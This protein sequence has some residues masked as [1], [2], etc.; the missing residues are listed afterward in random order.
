VNT[1]ELAITLLAAERRVLE[2]QTKLHR[3]ATNDP[4]KK[5]DDLFN[6]VTDPAFLLVA[7]DRV[8]GNKG[9]KTPGVDGLTAVSVQ[10]GIG[11][12]RF[13]SELR[14]ALKDR[15][16]QPLPVRERMIPKADGKLRRLGIPT[17]ADRVVQASLKLVLEP[18]FEADFHPCSYGFRPNRRAHDAVAEIVFLTNGPRRFDWI[19]EG[20][21]K[22]CFDEISHPALMHRV[23]VRIS[24]KRV[25]DL[26]KA[27]L[28]A[29]ILSEE[30]MLRKTDA[31][32]PQ[33]AILSPLLSNI[34][35]SV[36]D[37]YIAQ[38][39]GGPLLSAHF[40]AKRRSQGLPTYR[41]V[42]Y[43]DDWCLM[44]TGTRADAESLRDEI[45]EVLSTM[46][47]RLSPEKT[48]ITH[49]ALSGLDF[50]GWH[51]QRHVKKGTQDQ[52]Y[53]YNYPS[54]KALAR[55]IGKIKTLCRQTLNQDLADLLLP[56]NRLLHGWCTYF[57]TGVSFKTFQYLRAFVWR[58][59]WMWIRRKHPKSN[60]KEL[61]R[62]YC[63]GG[64]W[65][66]DNGVQLF[67][68]GSVRTFTYRYR[69]AAIP[70]PWSDNLVRAVAA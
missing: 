26:V 32:A 38:A 67:N 5:F 9:A 47:L 55:I 56:I 15:T 51:I 16:F 68:P 70:T 1:D 33:G 28:K 23:R 34:A 17:V 48:L 58:H 42:R 61:R 27:F 18:I 69:G 37:E 63:A 41:L 11:V 7:W 36:L 54:K 13:L 64:W 30:R 62:R 46:G 29:G 3:W 59:V 52:R 44:I 50:L 45:A 53:V 14:S 10:A 6:L 2:I 60:W 35:L 39:P 43:A 31:G 57:K 12:D 25:L 65:P 49:I 4:H 20:D 21:I 24:D 66:S 8:R 19:V 22:A 40:R